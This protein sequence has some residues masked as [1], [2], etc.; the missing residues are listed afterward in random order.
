MSILTRVFPDPFSETKR[1]DR[2]KREGSRDTEEEVK[3][4]EDGRGRKFATQ[5]RRHK[6]R[7]EAVYQ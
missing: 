2:P 5:S 6:L 1:K 4:G 7:N 3:V